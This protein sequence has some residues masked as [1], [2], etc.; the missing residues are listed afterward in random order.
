MGQQKAREEY[1]V[2]ENVLLLLHIAYTL[3]LLCWHC[4]VPADGYASL[5]FTTHSLIRC[6]SLGGNNLLQIV[7]AIDH[8]RQADPPF[9]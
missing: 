4:H 5:A 7:V 8:G 2:C 1:V 9:G 3:S 6:W